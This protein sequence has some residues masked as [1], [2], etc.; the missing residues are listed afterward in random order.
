[1]GFCSCEDYNGGAFYAFPT[2]NPLVA[3]EQDTKCFEC[4]KRLGRGEDAYA[5]EGNFE[6]LEQDF[7]DR[8]EAEWRNIWH[9]VVKDRLDDRGLDWDERV[10]ISKLRPEDVD[11]DDVEWCGLDEPEYICGWACEKCGDLILSVLELDMCWKPGGLLTQ[12]AEWRLEKR[13]EQS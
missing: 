3:L 11:W 1:M 12:L 2:D 4:G 7:P 6:A 13:D 5:I 9:A 10:A 8:A